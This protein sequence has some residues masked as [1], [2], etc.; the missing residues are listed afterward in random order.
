MKNF[1]DA[2]SLQYLRA[3]TVIIN[4]Q[5]VEL[6]YQSVYQ[7][8]IPVATSGNPFASAVVFTSAD[9]VGRANWISGNADDLPM[10]DLDMSESVKA[11]QTA[12]IGYGYG[13]QELNEA[14]AMGINLTADKA[15]AARRAYEEFVDVLAFN[16]DASKSI[17]GLTNL[18]SGDRQRTNDNTTGN[19]NDAAKLTKLIYSNLL[20]TGKNNN[21]TANTVLLP[22]KLFALLASSF[23]ANGSTYLNQI[24]TGNPVTGITGNNLT[25]RAVAGLDTASKD[26]NERIIMYRKDPTVLQLHIPMPHRFLPVHQAGPLRFEVPGVFRIAGIN[27]KRPDDVLYLDHDAS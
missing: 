23:L 6:D 1:T 22:P 13:W 4:K 10:A 25:I 16:G 2:D 5:A 26:D 24:Q 8:L 3:Q 9:K 18:G 17:T 21:P 20:E 12:A 11:V 14:Q 19:W 27:V 7:Q 15:T